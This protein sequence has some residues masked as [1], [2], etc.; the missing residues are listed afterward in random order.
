MVITAFAPAKINLYLHVTGRRALQFG[1]EAD[2]IKPIEAKLDR[3]LVSPTRAGG[4]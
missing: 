4:G 3:G 1:P 2:E